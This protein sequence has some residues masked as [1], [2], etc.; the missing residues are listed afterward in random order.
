MVEHCVPQGVSKNNENPIE[1]DFDEVLEEIDERVKNIKEEEEGRRTG[2][3]PTSSPLRGPLE[4]KHQ[5]TYQLY[6]V[7]RT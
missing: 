4:L 6:A 2:Q 5:R 3:P 1:E 7:H